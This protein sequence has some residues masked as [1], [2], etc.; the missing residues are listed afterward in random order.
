M[1]AP[2]VPCVAWPLVQLGPKIIGGKEVSSRAHAAF[3]PFVNHAHIPAVS[4]P[5]GCDTGGL[6]FGIQ[7]MARRGQDRLLLR[8]ARRIEREIA[9]MDSR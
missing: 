3:T 1:L 7:I 2:T 4:I 8:V 5:C 9:F 6:P